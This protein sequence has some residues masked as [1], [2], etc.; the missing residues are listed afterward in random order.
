MNVA[1]Q[2]SAEGEHAMRPGERRRFVLRDHQAAAPPVGRSRLRLASLPAVAASQRR[3]RLS[4][5]SLPALFSPYIKGRCVTQQRL[6][7]AR[8]FL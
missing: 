5:H 3:S 4:F 2:G 1:A 7:F 8:L 6:V